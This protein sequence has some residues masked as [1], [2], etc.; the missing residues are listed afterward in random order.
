[1]SDFSV[2]RAIA[3]CL[4]WSVASSGIIFLNKH[5]MANEG[6]RFPMA[7][8]CLGMATSS[9]CSY[10]A[11]VIFGVIPRTVDITMDFWFKRAL[12]IGMCGALTLYFGNLAY[13]YISVPYIQM[14]KG[15][16][17]I[18]TLA[19]G[20]VFGI[21]A[22][23]LPLCASLVSIGG[24]V[25]LSSYAE[26][27]F[28]LTGFLCM[29]AAETFEAG[30]VVLMQKLMSG[31]KLH[32]LEG[33]L[34]FAPPC[35]SCLFIGTLLL[36]LDGML[37]VGIPKM[38]EKPWLFLVQGSMGFVVNLLILQVIKCTSSVTFKVVSMMKN[39]A[40]VVGSIPLFGDRVTALQGVGYAISMAGFAAYQ[41]ARSIQGPI[42]PAKQRLE[43]D[44]EDETTSLNPKKGPPAVC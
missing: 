39:V 3:S 29:L 41:Y 34:C 8:S 28:V 22:A 16:T 9:I 10:V 43:E 26:A 21:D 31:H 12:P 2:I 38:I 33:L 40:V 20:I 7:L 17:P 11:I 44:S 35:A 23:T 13:L 19:I 36:E 6:F 4:A 42:V 14:L 18:I 30:K 25:T 1:M 37:T 5:I 27:E 24:G 32:V 15:M